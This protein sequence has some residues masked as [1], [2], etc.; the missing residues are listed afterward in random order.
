MRVRVKVKVRVSD[1]LGCVTIVHVH[2]M[3]HLLDRLHAQL[4]LARHQG[5]HRLGRVRVR[6]R[7]R[8]WLRVMARVMVRVRVR[9]RVRV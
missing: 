2:R 6:V 7:V 4:D 3:G 8:A 9:V 5:A 1:H